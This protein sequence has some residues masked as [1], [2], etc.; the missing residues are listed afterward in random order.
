MRQISH[1]YC[2]R[3]KRFFDSLGIAAHRAAHRRREEDCEIIYSSGIVLQHQF[4]HPS[5]T[6]GKPHEVL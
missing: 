4:S 5:R 6:A 2:R 1:C 3:C